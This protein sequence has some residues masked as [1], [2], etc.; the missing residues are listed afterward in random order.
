MSPSLPDRTEEA[1]ANAPKTRWPRLSGAADPRRR[2][3]SRSLA[4]WQIGP[5]GMSSAMIRKRRASQLLSANRKRAS[6]RPSE[7][8]TAFLDRIK[9]RDERDQGLC[10]RRP[11]RSPSRRREAVNQKRKQRQPL[12]RLAGLPDCPQGRRLHAGPADDLRLAAFSRISSP[13]YDATIVRAAEG[14]RRRARSA[15]RTWTSSRWAR[16]PRTR[17]LQT[18]RNPWDTGTERRADRAADRR[19]PSRRACVALAIGSDTGGFD[20]PAGRFLRHRGIKPTY[21]RVSRYGLMAYA[22]SL[23]QLGPMANDV[24]GAAM[25]LEVMAGHDPADSRIGRSSRAGV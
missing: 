5:N 21:G 17:R 14:G 9:E 12:G 16:P 11:D 20:P 1:L 23:D 10:A 13:P 8:A 2:L 25:L 4:S 15:K 22:S 24:A 7:I 18:T 3:T 19:R 6:G